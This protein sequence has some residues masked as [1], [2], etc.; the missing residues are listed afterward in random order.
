MSVADRPG[1]PEDGVVLDVSGGRG[2]RVARVGDLYR[3]G[4]L[5]V[6]IGDDVAQVAGQ[7]LVAAADPALLVGMLRGPAA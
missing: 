3:A 1:T 6:A 5:L 4:Q 7:I 2:G